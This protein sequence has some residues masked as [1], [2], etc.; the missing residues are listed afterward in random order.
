M[1][2]I[3][4]VAVIGCGVAGITSAIQLKR[5]DFEPIIFEKSVIGGLLLNANFV[6][7]YP[8]FP[9][10][11]T[12]IE[13]VKIFRK[14]LENLDIKI[15]KTKVLK[16]NCKNDFFEI[17]T[18]NGNFYFKVVVVATGTI[19]KRLDIDGEKNLFKKKLFYEIKNLPPLFG[20][21]NFL[22]VGGGDCAFDYALNLAKKGIS[23]KILYRGK[24]PKCLPLLKERAK[25]NPKIEIYPE[26]QIFCFKNDRKIKTNCRT[27]TKEFTLQSDYVLVAIGR[28][29]NYS[30]LPMQALKIEKNGK[31]SIPGLYL[32]GDVIGSYRQVGIAVGSALSTA[33]AINDYLNR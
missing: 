22:I 16:I 33:M 19:P 2:E 9:S 13:L 27:K 12:G 18:I 32:A 11:I 26:T 6:E 8:G 3:N 10:G 7:N 24:K 17:K 1:R 21:E 4:E 30:I 23:S 20:D 25:E 31:T 15:I 14:H 29:P 5:S 28:L